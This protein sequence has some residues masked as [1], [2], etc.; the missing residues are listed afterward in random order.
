MDSHQA[1]EGAIAVAHGDPFCVGFTYEIS[2]FVVDIA[3]RSRIR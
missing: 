1:V 2:R 3:H